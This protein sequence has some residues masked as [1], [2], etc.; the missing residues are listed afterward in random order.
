MIVSSLHASNYKLTMPLSDVE[1]AQHAL[2]FAIGMLRVPTVYQ[3]ADWAPHPCLSDD[4]AEPSILGWYAVR[5][6][7]QRG[8]PARRSDAVYHPVI[9]G[10]CISWSLPSLHAGSP[11]G[12]PSG[13]YSRGIGA[14]EK[15]VGLLWHEYLYH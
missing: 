13:I 9:L 1:A 6:T 7:S 11:P 5:N 10:P 12:S 15:L 8:R 3:S 14:R 2:D 4:F